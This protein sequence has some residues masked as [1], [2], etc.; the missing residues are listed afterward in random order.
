[1]HGSIRLSTRLPCWTNKSKYIK[2]RRWLV[3]M[4]SMMC[5]RRENMGRSKSCVAV[6]HIGLDVRTWTVFTEQQT[7]PKVLKHA[8]NLEKD[9]KV[10]FQRIRLLATPSYATKSTRCGM[11]VCLSRMTTRFIKERPEFCL[12]A[13]NGT[14]I[15]FRLVFWT[16]FTKVSVGSLLKFDSLV[17]TS[18][19]L[20]ATSKEFPFLSSQTAT[21]IA[22]AGRFR[23][24]WYIG[25][26]GAQISLCRTH[27]WCQVMNRWIQY[28]I[29]PATVQKFFSFV[30]NTW[31]SGVPSRH[32]CVALTG[33]E[34]F[35][36][37][38][39]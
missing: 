28:F 11:F 21:R 29:G 16:N 3:E 5:R 25:K 26:D 34:C 30:V 2:W 32:R 22:E 27:L 8:L 4:K 12:C 10:F 17:L 24:I 1:M 18:C 31:F 7:L 6:E 36:W 20:Y 37:P 39:I 38:F 35:F 9:C 19:S 14:T 33:L 23:P 15:S 13:K